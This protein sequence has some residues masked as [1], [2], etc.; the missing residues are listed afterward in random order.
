MLI[1]IRT[2]T[3]IRRTPAANYGLIA[4]NVF[5]YLLWQLGPAWQQFETRHLVLHAEEPAVY[6]YVTYQF[7]HDHSSVMHLFGN[8]LFL[9]VFGNAVN[10]KMGHLSYVL[11]Y[12]AGGA[13][14]GVGFAFFSD[15]SL[16]GA[17]GAIAAVTTA[18][19]A[20]FPRSRIMFL[21]WLIIIG[22]IEL[23]SMLIITLKIVLWDNIL[24][25]RWFGQGG[26]VAYSAHLAGYT[27]GFTVACLMLLLRALPRD[28]FDIIALWKRWRQR[29]VFADVMR[30]PEAQAQAQF[31][32]VAARP[33][34]LDPRQAAATAALL[35]RIG[36]LRAR[37]NQALAENDRATAAQLY[38][39]LVTIDPKQVLSLQHMLD[40]GNQLYMMH[41]YP[42]AAAC[43]ERFLQHFPRSAEAQHV[44]LLLGI[45]YA[46]DLQY[47]E[48][49]ERHLRES[50]AEL[51]DARRREQCGRWLEVVASALGRPKPGPA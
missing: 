27:F 15:D 41:R 23:P 45:I 49:A 12:L 31:G 9:W 14:A 33:V 18:Y 10:A 21:Y 38:E 34:A 32:R 24:E 11:F 17:S 37:I 48:A 43:Y 5:I 46:R 4:A 39:E 19:L 36:E 3:P 13:F 44:R 51:T 30:P 20:L 42:Q 22:F 2:D 29:R 8:M 40:V 25:P 47:Y 16:V 7:L 50:M 35:D 6:Q 26:G 28:Q 1:P